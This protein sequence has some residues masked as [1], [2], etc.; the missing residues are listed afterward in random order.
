MESSGKN[1]DIAAQVRQRAA[2][3]LPDG[4]DTARPAV[5]ITPEFV[6]Q[7][8]DANERGDGVLYAHLNRGRFLYRISPDG[9]GEW[10]AWGG[11]YWRPD[12]R[13]E[14][15]AAVERCA[16]AY[17][18]QAAALDAEIQAMHIEPKGEGSWRIKRRDVF[19]KGADRLR[20]TTGA[21]RCLRW[22]PIV[23]HPTTVLD[24]QLDQQPM[25]LPCA[26][27]VIDLRTG[28]LTRGRPDDLLCRA[29]DLEYD[30]H[31]DYTPWQAF[32]DEVSGSADL[33]SFIKRSLGYAIT[34]N[35]HEQYVWV[36]TGPG[37]NGKGVLFGLVGEILGPYYRELSRG[38]LIEQRNEL[39]PASASEHLYSLLGR[40]IVVGAET[41]RGQRID[42][43]GVKLLTGE[44]KITC[45]PLFKS[46]ISF[47]PSHTLFLHTNHIPA[48]LTGDF[49]MIQRLLKVEFPY[50]YVDDPAA[51]AKKYPLQADLFRKKDPGLKVRLRACRQGILRW[52]VEGCL[53]WQLQGISPPLQVAEWVNELA[54]EEDYIR[55]FVDDCLVQSEVPWTRISATDMYDAFR[56]WWSENRDI[57]IKRIPQLKTITADL[58][59]RGFSVE[60]TGGRY[61]CN[62][63]HLSFEIA[64]DVSQ[65]VQAGGGRP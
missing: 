17:A 15:F 48:G 65:Y 8:R 9:S 62:G 57:R 45:R 60:K 26:N 38:M 18:E 56:W 55:Q 52:L 49:A 14:S 27:G 19:Q 31:A 24:H 10:L 54:I 6:G 30:P 51:E 2:E 47:N 63:L 1:Q 59:N 23:D 58:R 40:R 33:A 20:T 43:A 46:E 32:I 13:A 12:Q 7:C 28:A 39:S 21:E 61:W 36:F 25:L 34:G 35:S 37:R 64:D 44:D 5:Q 41:N 3:L 11:H 4:A 22:A 50:M 42:A 29:I 53:E 16:L